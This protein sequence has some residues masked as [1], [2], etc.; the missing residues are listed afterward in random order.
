M[1]KNTKARAAGVQHVGYQRSQATFPDVLIYFW[2]ELDG[3]SSERLLRTPR[4]V[5]KMA[6]RRE[7]RQDILFVSL[8]TYS[9]RY[10]LE[11]CLSSSSHD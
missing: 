7:E 1:W 2:N 4:N 3:W 10:I 5:R 11:G 8:F 9:V 6:Q